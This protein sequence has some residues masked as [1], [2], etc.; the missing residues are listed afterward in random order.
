MTQVERKKE[1]YEKVYV[2]FRTILDKRTEVLQNE[3][4]KIFE[5]EEKQRL[6]KNKNREPVDQK[7]KEIISVVEPPPLPCAKLTVED[8]LTA[9]EKLI[10]CVEKYTDLKGVEKK[11]MV[12]DLLTLLFQTLGGDEKVAILVYNTSSYLIDTIIAI[13]NQGSRWMKSPGRWER[14]KARVSCSH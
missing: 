9:L 13:Y 6:K 5:K 10:K 4:K 1:I 11:E 3:Q 2:E 12:L 8:T 7:I 14:F